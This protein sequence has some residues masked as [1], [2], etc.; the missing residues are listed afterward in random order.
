[1]PSPAL[2]AALAEFEVEYGSISGLFATA[3][4]T[5]AEW[6]EAEP[7]NTSGIAE[8]QSSADPVYV[9]FVRGDFA[10]VGPPVLD[11]PGT[12]QARAE[13]DIGRVVFDAMGTLLNIRLWSSNE[14]GP[15]IT[16]G[17]PPIGPEFDG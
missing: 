16:T 10:A 12:N 9:A 13:Y 6:A 11:D 8:S 2:E 7:G 5:M 17:D 15:P 1:V 4:A 3:S 14:V